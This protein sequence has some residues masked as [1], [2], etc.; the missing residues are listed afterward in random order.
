ML[1]KFHGWL[2]TPMV[3]PTQRLCEWPEHIESE[4]AEQLACLLPVLPLCLPLEP[5][6][7]DHVLVL[8]LEPHGADSSPW[9]PLELHPRVRRELSEV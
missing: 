3:D 1:G 9:L 7:A 8:P 4:C 2:P 5:H 6:G